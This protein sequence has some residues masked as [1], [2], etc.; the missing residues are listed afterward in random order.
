VRSF[1]RAAGTYDGSSTVQAAS[2]ERLAELVATRTARIDRL[3]D[4]GCGTGRAARCLGE[5]VGVGTVVG[6]DVAERMLRHARL[7]GFKAL[8]VVADAEALPIASGAVDVAVANFVFQWIQRPLAAARE[9]AR[10]LAPT[11]CLAVSV[12]GAG[13]LA[14]LR[15]A[16]R[17]VLGPVRSAR[18][19]GAGE[20]ARVLESA[21]F[22]V[23]AVERADFDVSYD[24]LEE[25]LARLK[26]AG[27]LVPAADAGLGGRERLRRLNEAIGDRRPIRTRYV[28]HYFLAQ[29][30]RGA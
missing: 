28:V 6:V 24:S 11:G 1:S 21:R 30:A 25:M 9:L 17:K 29:P 4:V 15:G 23:T 13:T 3:L 5:R 20:F 26:A 18:F 22:S 19:Y 27:A 14:Q 7:G 10:V 16:I 8:N 2:A 12:M